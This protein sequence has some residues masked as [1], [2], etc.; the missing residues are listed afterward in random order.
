MSYP[1]ACSGYDPATEIKYALNGVPAAMQEL[2]LNLAYE[3]A[4]K[5]S[6]NPY[7]DSA[8]HYVDGVNAADIRPNPGAPKRLTTVKECTQRYVRGI[9][10][11]RSKLT[12][13]QQESL[14]FCSDADASLISSGVVDKYGKVNVERLDALLPAQ[15][16]RDWP[17]DAV[18]RLQVDQEALSFVVNDYSRALHALVRQRKDRILF[19]LPVDDA[20]RNHSYPNP[21][22]TITGRE[23]PK[24][25]AFPHLSKRQRTILVAKPGN[26]LANLDYQQQEPAIALVFAEDDYLLDLYAT[27]DLYE[28]L[29]AT[30]PYGYTRDVVKQI[31]ISRLYGANEN[32]FIKNLG[33][34]RSEARDCI[35]RLDSILALYRRWSDRF[36]SQAFTA[37]VVHSM[38]WRLAVHSGTP[39][40]TLRN[41]PIQAAGADI[42]RRACLLLDQAEIPV[43]GCIHDSVIIEVPMPGYRAKIESAQ[44][45]MADASAEVLRGF[46]L[47]TKIERLVDEYGNTVGG[48]HCG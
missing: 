37:G 46:R 2:S 16:V 35:N 44:R 22:G 29:A 3:C 24:G 31:T 11:S 4:L 32:T 14:D 26:V 19:N 43:V 48:V 10:I 36:V 15:A 25:F 6:A 38:D 21:F 33:M 30:M 5:L 45:L 23:N 17:R 20:E 34:T 13:L 41:W 1:F 42:L 9:R 7:S 18:G 39:I 8:V 27:R 28:C 40:P 12:E 47:R